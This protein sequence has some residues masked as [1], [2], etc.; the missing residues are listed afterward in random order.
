MDWISAAEAAMKLEVSER[1]VRR[2]AADGELDA[3]LVSGR[4]LVKAA[5]VRDRA[6]AEP[7]AG[8]PLS[9][10]MAW[11][12]LAVVAAG[13][14]DELD[15]DPFEGFGD[16]RLRHRLRSL[17]ADPPSP[18][19]WDRWL[20]RRAHPE[21]V[22]VHPGVL[23]RLASDPRLHQGGGPAAAASGAGLPG[24]D[25]NLFYVG[26]A[27]AGSVMADHRARPDDEGQV[28]LMVVPPEAPKGALGDP[29]SAVSPS[30]ALVDLLGS[31]DARERHGA[32]YALSKAWQ[33]VAEADELS[34]R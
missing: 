4:W 19:Q 8:R 34:V 31:P 29:G 32:A 10:Q 1:Q 22:W 21:R 7:R 15:G 27:D 16:R 30:V 6:R 13:F 5:A 20:R 12:V 18:E 17:V 25:R 14:S 11:A 24:G 2:L 26:A 9:P 33:R 3:R 23:D 28:V